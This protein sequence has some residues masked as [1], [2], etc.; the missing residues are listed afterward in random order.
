M[1]RARTEYSLIEEFKRDIIRLNGTPGRGLPI[2]VL[3]PLI[4]ED[5]MEL[6]VVGTPVGRI[7]DPDE[8]E[9]FPFIILNCR[10]PD[11][12]EDNCPVRC[13]RAAYGHQIFLKGEP[14]QLFVRDTAGPRPHL[15]FM[16]VPIVAGFDDG[17]LDVVK[18]MMKRLD[19]VLMR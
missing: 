5:R 19:G 16:F 3:M 6:D 2:G 18:Y 12:A 11:L 14:D 7:V 1:D 10:D 13:G 4:S 15:G 9:T 8:D 17:C